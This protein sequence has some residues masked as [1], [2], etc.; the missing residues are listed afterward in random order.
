MTNAAATS[1]PSAA[2]REP[3]ADQTADTGGHHGRDE[4]QRGRDRLGE[5]QHEPN[6]EHGRPQSLQ[7]ID[8][9]VAHRQGR[10]T[11]SGLYLT[12]PNHTCE[13]PS[14]SGQHDERECRPPQLVT[15]VRAHDEE[16]E[17]PTDD[18]P[19]TGDEHES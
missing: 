13:D 4:D 6:A 9:S 3:H 1:G 2:G 12:S 14:E 10:V 5:R 16:R 19:P 7:Q 15:V 17:I 8:H 18:F 11:R